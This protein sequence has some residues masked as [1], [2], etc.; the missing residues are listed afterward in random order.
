MVSKK[1]VNSFL[2]R[3]Y[4]EYSSLVEISKVNHKIREFLL[5]IQNHLDCVMKILQEPCAFFMSIK[6][7]VHSVYEQRLQ[8]LILPLGNRL[9][10]VSW[11]VGIVFHSHL[12]HESHGD[13]YRGCQVLAIMGLVQKHWTLYRF[14]RRWRSPSISLRF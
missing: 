11:P 4:Y 2:C 13:S 9:V 5:H 1:Y 14:L 10:L 8:N 7:Y 6:Q 3:H 12:Y